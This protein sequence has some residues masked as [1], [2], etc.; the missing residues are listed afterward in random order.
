MIKYRWEEVN[1][2]RDI[3]E[4][5]VNGHQFDRDHGRRLALFLAEKFPHSAQTMH[6]VA[7][8]MGE[9]S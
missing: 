7:E 6:R 8:R 2:L 1:Q 4:A 9:R 3:L 5:E